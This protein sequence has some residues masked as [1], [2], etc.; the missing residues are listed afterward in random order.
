M[1]PRQ[2]IAQQLVPIDRYFV[3]TQERNSVP[4]VMPDV[5]GVRIQQRHKPTFDALASRFIT[6]PRQRTPDTDA[7]APTLR[8]RGAQGSEGATIFAQTFQGCD[9]RVTHARTSWILSPRILN[10]RCS[11]RTAAL[12]T[13]A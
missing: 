13:R 7:G 3:R 8:G 6:Y 12:K 11:A 10:K 1:V 9:Q 5:L 2:Y 4:Q